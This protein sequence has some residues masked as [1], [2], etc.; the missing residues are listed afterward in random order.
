MPKLFYVEAS[1]RKESSH[2]IEIAQM[3][4]ESYRKAYPTDEIETIDLWSVDG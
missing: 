1:P 3:F 4:L 2:S